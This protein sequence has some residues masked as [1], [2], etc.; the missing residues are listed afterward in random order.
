M[1][2]LCLHSKHIILIS[3][4]VKSLS[5]I[6]YLT[7]VCNLISKIQK[8]YVYQNTGFFVRMNVSSQKIS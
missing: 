5:L 7:F 4:S 1:F 3:L 2:L 8:S 6:Y